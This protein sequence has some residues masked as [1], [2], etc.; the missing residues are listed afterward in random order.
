MDLATKLILEEIGRLGLKLITE[1]GM[2][3]TITPEDFKHFWKR[4]GEYTSSSMSGVH[5]G[6]YKVAIKCNI[7]TKI[8]VQQLKVVTQ[9]RIPLKNWS[10]GLQVML[11]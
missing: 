8:L 9:S 4:V 2:E 7:S 3:I 11:K 1:E 10:V 5:Y 6:H